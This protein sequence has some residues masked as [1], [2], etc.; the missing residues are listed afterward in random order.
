MP[1]IA[2]RCAQLFFRSWGRFGPDCPGASRRY[3]VLG[4]LKTPFSG[5]H[6]S[7]SWRRASRSARDST[8]RARVS[9]PAFFKLLS[10]DIA[11]ILPRGLPQPTYRSA[12]LVN[13]SLAPGEGNMLLQSSLGTQVGCPATFPPSR[14]SSGPR[15]GG[16]EARNVQPEKPGSRSTWED[17]TMYV[18]VNTDNHITGSD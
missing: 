1:E 16:P 11:P 4:R 8:L 9:P 2:K 3:L 18:E 10:I 7:S 13:R 14:P 15:I 17:A 6:F 12:R 5:L